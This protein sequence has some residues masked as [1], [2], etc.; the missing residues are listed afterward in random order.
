MAHTGAPGCV[1]HIESLNERSLLVTTTGSDAVVS[2]WDVAAFSSAATMDVASSK[3]LVAGSA[4][5]TGSPASSSFALVLDCEASTLHVWD[6][7]TDNA[8]KHTIHAVDGTPLQATALTAFPGG[9]PYAV[10]GSLGHP[11]QIHDL[12]NPSAPCFVFEGAADAGR[13]KSYDPRRGVFCETFA[14]V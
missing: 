6:V 5:D 7:R 8:G 1:Q 9:L 4:T 14:G 12:R 3:V 11:P 2:L 10:V 13:T